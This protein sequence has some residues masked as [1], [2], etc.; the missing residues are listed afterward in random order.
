MG[1][2]GFSLCGFEEFL[3][4][5][6]DAVEVMEEVVVEGGSGEVVTAGKSF[7]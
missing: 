7:F 6:C 3:L 2:C 4:K 5:S 1:C